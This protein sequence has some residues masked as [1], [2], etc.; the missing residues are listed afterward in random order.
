MSNQVLRCLYVF[1]GVV[2]QYSIVE[3][4]VKTYT[5]H[6]FHVLGCEEHGRSK[7]TVLREQFKEFSEN[8]FKVTI[9]RVQQLALERAKAI[10]LPTPAEQLS[11]VQQRRDAK[12]SRAQAASPSWYSC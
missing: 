3:P 1:L 5:A 12:K 8:T 2:S 6:C 11:L 7:T 4:D 9:N 10:K